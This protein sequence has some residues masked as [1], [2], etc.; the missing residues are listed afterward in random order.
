[1]EILFTDSYQAKQGTV[2]EEWGRL[3][4]RIN[5]RPRR[6]PRL[7]LRRSVAFA[8]RSRPLCPAQV[9]AIAERIANAAPGDG[10]PSAFAA[11][12][13]IAQAIKSMAAEAAAPESAL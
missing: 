6:Q 10:A 4:V 5:Y 7:R 9:K 2:V 13:A 8:P 1:M 3:A 12:R 11:A